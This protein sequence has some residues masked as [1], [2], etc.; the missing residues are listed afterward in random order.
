VIEL[1][2]GEY[3]EN[4]LRHEEGRKKEIRVSIHRIAHHR[5]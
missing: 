3:E 1:E 2:K 4:A 5:H